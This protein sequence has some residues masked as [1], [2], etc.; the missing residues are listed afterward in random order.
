M[1]QDVPE[2]C[3]STAEVDDRASNVQSVF[4][5]GSLIYKSE[6][7]HSH[8][9]VAYIDGYVR[10]FYQGSIDHRGTADRPGRVVTLLK[11]DV[12]ED[13]KYEPGPARVYGMLYHLRAETRTEVLASLDFREKNGYTRTVEEA[14]ASDG[15]PLGCVAVYRATPEN[16]QY[17]GPASPRSLGEHIAG[18]SGPSGPN[19]EYVFRLAEALKTITPDDATADRHAEAVS[20]SCRAAISS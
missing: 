2:G 7:D 17:A 11:V 6:F 9:E 16:P 1:A 15:K 14:F 4:G 3:W 13:A 18:C 8:C 20:Q 5:Y 12:D 19:P 10:R